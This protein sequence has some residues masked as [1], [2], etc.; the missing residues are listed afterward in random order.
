MESILRD[1]I[2]EFL[3][4]NLLIRE[5]PHGFRIRRNYLTNLLEFYNWVTEERDKRNPVDIVYFDL[6][7]AFDNV[8]HKRLR[9]K[10]EV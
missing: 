10:L 1:H 2:L 4:G 3:E 5:S 9:A 8:S 6:A 7:R